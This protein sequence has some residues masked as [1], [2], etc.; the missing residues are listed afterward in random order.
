MMNFSVVSMDDFKVVFGLEFQRQVSAIPMHAVS[1]VCILEKGSPCMIPT[2]EA[3]SK[4]DR[5]V[6]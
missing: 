6:R 1:T 2:V 3:K 5:E 4:E